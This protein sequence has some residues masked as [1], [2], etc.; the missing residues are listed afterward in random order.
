[1]LCC[2][3]QGDG[4][5]GREVLAHHTGGPVRLATFLKTPDKG[6]YVSTVFTAALAV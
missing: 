5:E 4:G 2:V 1:M 3:V 6:E